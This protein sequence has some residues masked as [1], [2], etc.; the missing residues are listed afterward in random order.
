MRFFWYTTS[1]LRP[2]NKT[3]AGAGIR[4]MQHARMEYD[5]ER[6]EAA[7]GR[8]AY[9]GQQTELGG[10]VLRRRTG[11]C[12]CWPVRRAVSGLWTSTR[13]SLCACPSASPSSRARAPLCSSLSQ[14]RPIELT[15]RR[16]HSHLL[17]PLSIT[18]EQGQSSAL[19]QPS[20]VMAQTLRL[21]EVLLSMYAPV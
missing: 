3:S 2:R 20:A 16:P 14:A 1:T 4:A 21:L 12:M 17:L 8:E 19:Q 13:R 7:H 5:R 9:R 11:I 6:S 15:V 10:P 18:T